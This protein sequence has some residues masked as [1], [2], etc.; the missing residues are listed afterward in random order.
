V[1]LTIFYPAFRAAFP[2]AR[3][4]KASTEHHHA[5]VFR[6]QPGEKSVQTARQ[7]IIIEL[8]RAAEPST[9]VQAISA[10][11]RQTKYL[12]RLI[13]D[14]ASVEEACPGN[15]TLHACATAR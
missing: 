10:L 5:C 15:L 3:L 11:E 8:L 7:K 12:V 9:E 1:S 14:L 2:P 6:G 13:D 4:R